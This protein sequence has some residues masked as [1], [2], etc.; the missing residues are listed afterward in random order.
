MWFCEG[1][2][3]FFKVAMTLFDLFEEELLELQE[4]DKFVETIKNYSFKV[5]E[6]EFLKNLCKQKL[7]Q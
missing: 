6:K 5:D 4:N 1:Y 3:V 2:N 7:F